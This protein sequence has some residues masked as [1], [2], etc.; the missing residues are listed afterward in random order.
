MYHS[1]R[2]L[3]PNHIHRPLP[4]PL[5]KRTR[6]LD[7]FCGTRK[8]DLLLLVEVC[9]THTLFNIIELTFREAGQLLMCSLLVCGLGM[10]PNNQDRDF[11]G[12]A[13]E[14]RN[15]WHCFREPEDVLANFWGM[16]QDAEWAHKAAVIEF[17]NNAI[18]MSSATMLDLSTKKFDLPIAEFRCGVLCHPLIVISLLLVQ[19]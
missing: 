12:G 14:A 1:S 17:V 6:L 9:W 15:L 2:A 16:E 4:C 8:D 10:S 13:A 18:V 5:G 7:Q 19:G 11:A 3:H